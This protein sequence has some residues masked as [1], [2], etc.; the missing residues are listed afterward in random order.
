MDDNQYLAFMDLLMCSDPWPVQ[1]DIG[2]YEKEVLEDLANAEARAR[3]FD[4]WI[5]AY[6]EMIRL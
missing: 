6:H 2:I 3:N 4:D 5:V 1:G